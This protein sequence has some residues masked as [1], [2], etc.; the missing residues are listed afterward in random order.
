MTIGLPDGSERACAFACDFVE[1]RAGGDP[2]RTGAP[3]AYA[4]RLTGAVAGLAEDVT[5]WGCD[6]RLV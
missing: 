3:G 6:C 1:F 2:T 4:F 5:L